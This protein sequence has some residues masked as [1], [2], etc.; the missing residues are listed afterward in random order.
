MGSPSLWTY[1]VTNIC[2]KLIPGLLVLYNFLYHEENLNTDLDS[3]DIIL[4]LCLLF[5]CIIG[6]YLYLLT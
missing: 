2:M 6:D 1:F 5:L 3:Q 4:Q